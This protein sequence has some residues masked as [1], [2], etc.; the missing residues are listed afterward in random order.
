MLMLMQQLNHHD[1][2]I[3]SD[4]EVDVEW[5]VQRLLKIEWWMGTQCNIECL[6]CSDE[7]LTV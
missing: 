2:L 3:E 5:V 7:E 1:I 6:A 4:S